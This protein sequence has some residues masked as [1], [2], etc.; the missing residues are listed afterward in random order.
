MNELN[1]HTNPE[2]GTNGTDL[3]KE[4][5]KYY[6]FKYW[7]IL[8]TV[9]CLISGF[10]YLRYAQYLYETTAKI[11]II[12]KSMDNEMALPTAMTIFNRSMINLENE[13]GVLTSYSLHS[14]VVKKLNS[15]IKFYTVGNIK[16]TENHLSDWTEI[17]EFELK[18]DSDTISKSMS[19]EIEYDEKYMIITNLDEESNEVYKFESSSTML[20]NHDLPFEMSLNNSQIFGSKKIIS[21]YP[22]EDIVE[23]FR[24][25]VQVSITSNESDQL[26]L[27][28]QYPNSHISEEYIN[29][30]IDEFD[31]D[32]IKD[33]RSEYKRTVDFV[34]TRSSLLLEELEKIEFQKLEYKKE[35]KLTDLVTDASIKISEKTTYDNELFKAKSQK[36]LSKLLRDAI[37]DE[38]YKLLP[39]NIGIE[40]QSINDIIND[41]NMVINERSSYLM[42]AGPNNS[43]VKTIE[44]KLDGI[45]E[46]IIISIDN[47]QKNLDVKINNLELKEKELASVYDNVPQSE[48][49]LR[50]IERELSIK[51]ALFLLLLQKREEASINYAVVKPSIKV[52]DYGRTPVN[53]KSPRKLLIIVFVFILGILIPFSILYVYFLLDNKVQTRSD[54]EIT[55]LPMLTQIPFLKNHEKNGYLNNLLKEDRSAISESV[56]MMIAN[57]N[58]SLSDSKNPISTVL[59]TSCIKGEGKTLVSAYLSKILSFSDDKKV[60]LI[61]TDLRNPQLHKSISTTKDLKGLSD[62]IYRNDLNYKDLILKSGNL[63]I[64]LSGTVPPSP[65]DLLSSSKF[66]NLL[67]Q[68][69]KDY[70]HVIID[71]APCLFLSDTFQFSKLVDFSIVV[72]RANH[73]PKEIISYINELRTSNKLNN[74]NLV[75]NGIGSNNMYGYDYEYSYGY[76][77]S[78]GYDYSYSD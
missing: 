75:L 31:L 1:S 19:Y 37:F 16:T 54:F 45:L 30:L 4:F 26:V 74:I 38:P 58:F 69:K 48:K 2:F 66:A 63:D 51:E 34:D 43:I 28:M 70:D 14:S 24:T 27:S 22:F 15:N 10:I 36:D 61:G 18:I 33:R 8:S 17:E 46:N 7:F 57:L 64:L 52:I 25:A 35:N 55:G 29:N 71:S 77:Y 56:R 5:Q 65:T 3:L 62:F 13:I 49:V 60:I 59:V 20:A 6:S 9:V 23:Y 39:V 44:Q 42:S 68:L 40:S 76:K 72:A 11:E 67:N 41:Y 78:Y 21:L 47:Y 53:P 32:G 73:T 12:D 50:A